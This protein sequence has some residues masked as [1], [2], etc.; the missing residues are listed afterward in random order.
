METSNQEVNAQAQT[1]TVTPTPASQGQSEDLAK[2]AVELKARVEEL[3]RA[4]KGILNDLRSEREKR[5]ELEAARSTGGYSNTATPVVNPAPTS[6]DPSAFVT[7]LATKGEA[8]I[9]ER[10]ERYVRPVAD[11]LDTQR[12]VEFLAEQTGKKPSQVRLDKDLEKKLLDV[13][14]RYRISGKSKEEYVQSA[15]N[16]L[17]K[18]ELEAELNAKTAAAKAEADKATAEAARSAAVAQ[19]STVPV[20]APTPSGV[21]SFTRAE[22]AKMSLD[23]YSRN[24]AEIQKAIAS[25]LVK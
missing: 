10:I 12:A 11:E 8:A 18:E 1:P 4:N 19:N 22:I 13:G 17:K 14:Q 20:G 9:T 23:E 15:W 2:A 6:V 21:R 24:Q 5:Q 16:I 3:E 25:G 7:E